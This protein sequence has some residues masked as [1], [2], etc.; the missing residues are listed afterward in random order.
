MHAVPNCH[1]GELCSQGTRGDNMLPASMYIKDQVDELKQDAEQ[2][3][4]SHR[5]MASAIVHLDDMC[6][7]EFGCID[8]QL[9]HI[10]E[11]IANIVEQQAQSMKKIHDMMME[12]LGCMQDSEEAHHPTVCWSLVLPNGEEPQG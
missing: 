7:E 5:E 12:V 9:C 10:D 3:K 4:D 1:M 2:L 11:N 6:F 8:Q